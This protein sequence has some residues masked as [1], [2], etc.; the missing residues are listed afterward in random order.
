MLSLYTESVLECPLLEQGVSGASPYQANLWSTCC[1]GSYGGASFMGV[2]QRQRGVAA[3][4]VPRWGKEHFD[5]CREAGVMVFSIESSNRRSR[6]SNRSSMLTGPVGLGVHAQAR[7]D[8]ITADPT[9]PWGWRGSSLDGWTRV[10]L[11]GPRTGEGPS[12]AEPPRQGGRAEVGDQT[13]GGGCG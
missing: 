10:G 3:L 5:T 9:A 4:P 13:R 6:T 7:A 2:R 1:W 11:T 12:G 8:R